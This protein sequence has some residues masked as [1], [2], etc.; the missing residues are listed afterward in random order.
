MKL[1]ECKSRENNQIK[2]NITFQ[3]DF[4]VFVCVGLAEV[5]FEFVQVDALGQCEYLNDLL[6]TIEADL[7]RFF[8]VEMDEQIF[9]DS[10]DY[11]IKRF[12]ELVGVLFD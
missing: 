9:G 3:I 1:I 10:L 7:V 11:E 12:A 6:E 8:L 2:W 5:S 4:A